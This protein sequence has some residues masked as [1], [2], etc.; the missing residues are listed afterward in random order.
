MA[1]TP[2]FPSFICHYS[3]HRMLS[4]VKTQRSHDSSQSL[5]LLSETKGFLMA[6][7]S[8]LLINPGTKKWLQPQ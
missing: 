8:T 3:S 7:Q 2:I 5:I 4:R 1:I 6:K